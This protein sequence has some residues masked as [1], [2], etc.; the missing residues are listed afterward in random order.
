MASTISPLPL[1]RRLGP[2]GPD[3]EIVVPV[4][5]EQAAL[6]RSVRRLHR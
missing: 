1:P 6:E 2:A 4:H 5:N 3:V